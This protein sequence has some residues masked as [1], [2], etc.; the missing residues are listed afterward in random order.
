M[1]IY[2]LTGAGKTTFCGTTVDCKHTSPS[3]L[4]DIGGGTSTLTGVEIDV[5]RPDSLNEFQDVYDYLRNEN[6]KYKAV[7]LDGITGAQ[8]EVSMPVVQGIK[9]VDGSEEYPRLENVLPPKR[10]DWLRSHEHIRWIL[11]AYRDLCIMHPKK[12]RIHVFVTALE[13]K[14]DARS[15]ILPQLPGVLGP[16]SGAYFDVLAR[17][18]VEERETGDEFV[19]ARRL[20]MEERNDADGMKQLAKRR[21]SDLKPVMWNPTVDKL[22][23]KWKETR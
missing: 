12:R 15:L 1:L 8:Q 10:Q 6:D 11:R 17:L 22:M 19:Y 14:D 9:E 16:E 18:S 20:L 2:A 7:C 23:S 4:I 5:V 3:L 21:W 13:K